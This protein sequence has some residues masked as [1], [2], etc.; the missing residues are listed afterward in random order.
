M[1][2][3]ISGTVVRITTYRGGTMRKYSGWRDAGRDPAMSALPKVE[4]PRA[5]VLRRRN[6][7]TEV[8]A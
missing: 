8:V 1:L 6:G 7:K 4:G 5:M 3:K 2:R